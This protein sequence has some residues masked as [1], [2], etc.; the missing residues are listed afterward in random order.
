MRQL[1]AKSGLSAEKVSLDALHCKSQTLELIGQSKGKYLVGLKDNQKELKNQV[2][3]EIKEQAFLFKNETSE[4]GHGRVEVREDEIY[5]LLAMKKAERWKKCQI[6]TVI[7]VKREREMLKSG[8]RSVEDSYY[9]SNGVGK[10]EELCEAVRNHWQV[11]TNNH[12]RDVSLK[13]DEMR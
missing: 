1:L 4:K 5:D 11:E 13:E 8:K 9:V 3:R 2:S 10:Y 7:K 12:L 6:K